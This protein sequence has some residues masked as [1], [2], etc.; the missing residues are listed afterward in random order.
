M[1]YFFEDFAL[2]SERR[3]LRRGDDLVAVEPQVFDLL[4]YLVRNCG[5]VVSKDDLI[6][7][8][9]DGRIVSDVTIDTRVNAARRAI[10]DSGKDQRLI[11]TLPRKGIRFVG[12]VREERRTAEAGPAA[13]A[14][15]QPIPALALP[16]RPSI[17]VLPF[18]NMSGDPSRNI[19]RTESWRI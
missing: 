16:D 6:V 19:S 7:A 4:K 2:D 5:R 15:E 14:A 11:K 1:L 10:Q 18:T 17:A 9:W 13:I 8:V 12:A 3:E